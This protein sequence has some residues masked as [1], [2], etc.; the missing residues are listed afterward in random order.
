MS[1]QAPPVSNQSKGQDAPGS[2]GSAPVPTQAPP[3][4]VKP[5]QEVSQAGYVED[6]QSAEYQGVP[7]QPGVPIMPPVYPP[8]PGQVVIRWD[9]PQPGCCQCEGLSTQGWVAAVLLCICLGPCV[10]CS[11]YRDKQNLSY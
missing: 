4:A 8:Q 10:A 3:S 1:S 5:G 11:K 6:V 2:D 7:P 9:S